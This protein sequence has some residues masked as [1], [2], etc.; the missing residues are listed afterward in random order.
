[1]RRST[2]WILCLV[3][4]TACAAPAPAVTPRPAIEPPAPA[5]LDPS[6]PPWILQPSG[7]P[8]TRTIRLE[9]ELRS[10]VDT[11]ERRDSIRTVV[12]AEWSRVVGG[13]TVRL[14]GL[15]TDFRVGIDTA[16]LTIPQ[17]LSLPLPFA[18]LDGTET[19]AP[20]LIRPD[21]AGCGTEAAATHALREVFL[22]LPTRLEPTTTWR[23][24]ASYTICRDSVPLVAV[25]TRVY[26]V[27]GATR[28]A[29][30]LVIRIERHSRLTLR[31]AGR[32]FGEPIDIAA[33]GEGVATLFVPLAGGTVV[34]GTGESTLRMTMRGR[35]RSQELTQHTR[36]AISAP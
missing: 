25:S 17:G 21:P 34:E 2:R 15:L 35:R 7:A 33:D 23:D 36:I 9:T 10:R 11:V 5:A 18:A 1:M 13:G 24:S 8:V 12:T 3:S 27:M 16:E 26:R 20:R 28:L 30:E 4:A 14:S 31:G 29:G 19:V 6:S 32:Q 22:T